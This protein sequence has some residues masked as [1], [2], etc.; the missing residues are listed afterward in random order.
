MIPHR[1]CDLCGTVGYTSK[2]R[3]CPLLD[4]L[5]RGV[6][7]EDYVELSDAI[8]Q[9]LIAERQAKIERSKALACARQ[10]RQWERKKLAKRIKAEADAKNQ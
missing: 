9:V 8:R 10:K 5:G 7:P 1:T 3:K 6:R 4:C 2:P